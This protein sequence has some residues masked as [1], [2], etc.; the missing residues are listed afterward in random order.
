MKPIQYPR[1]SSYRPSTTIMSNNTIEQ[2]LRNLQINLAQGRT[3]DELAQ[4]GIYFPSSPQQQQPPPLPPQQQQ[5]QQNAFSNYIDSVHRALDSSK[6]QTKG[7]S[8]N[9]YYESPYHSDYI[10]YDYKRPP[11]FQIN[12]NQNNQ[13]PNFL[14][15]NNN[16]NPP[17]NLTNI[18]RPPV[19]PRQ[20]LFFSLSLIKPIGL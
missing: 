18:I 2:K 1:S 17:L 19:P 15:N 11:Q 9:I 8:N 6:P 14:N 4:A 20:G 12:F 13:Q 7:D 5:Q 3:Q 10:Q 16:N